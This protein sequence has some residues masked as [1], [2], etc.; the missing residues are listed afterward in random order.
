MLTSGT[1]VAIREPGHAGP[2]VDRHFYKQRWCTDC[3]GDDDVDW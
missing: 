2:K 1:E 3:H